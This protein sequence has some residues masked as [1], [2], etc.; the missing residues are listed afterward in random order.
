MEQKLSKVEDL[1]LENKCL[2][3]RLKHLTQSKLICLFDEVDR[4]T[5]SYK[6][7]INDLDKKYEELRNCYNS[8][9]GESQINLKNDKGDK[10]NFKK[11][12]CNVCESQIE[13]KRELVYEVAEY[14]GFMNTKIYNAIDC[15]KCGCQKIL[16]PR[17][18]KIN[19]DN[20]VGDNK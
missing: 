2:S 18:K 1:E 17:M 13:L 11:I 8:V 12:K 5:Q 15:Q 6:L 3:K 16:Y 9:F 14:N 7:N 10:M 4:N 20:K 19:L